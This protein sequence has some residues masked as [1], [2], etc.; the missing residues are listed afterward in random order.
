MNEI[1][2]SVVMIT[3]GHEKYIEEA[4]RGV[5]IQQTDF[6]I[7]LIIANDCSPDN[8]DEV[9]KGLIEDAPPNIEVKYSRHGENKGMM[10]NFIWALGQA[11]GKYIALCEGD[12]YWVDPYKLQKQ[13]D[14]METNPNF[15]M[16]FSG[17]EDIIENNLNNYRKITSF[18]KDRIFTGQEILDTWVV[19]TAS[20]LF[21]SRYVKE[22]D[23]EKTDSK[24]FIYGDIVLFLYLSTKGQIYGFKDKMV[25][26]RRHAD[27]VSVNSDVFG[28]F[29]KKYYAHLCEIIAVFGDKFKTPVF[30][31]QLSEISLDIAIK[32]LK[33]WH[34]LSAMRFLFK[35]I[36]HDYKKVVRGVILK[37]KFCK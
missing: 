25:A 14:F 28:N 20:V 10:P 12:D 6:N 18:D 23:Y 27:G 2:V 17:A 11:K 4:I 35:S 32:E 1:V 36:R 29:Q 16:I 22:E 13:V 8:T 33:K 26:Y 31:R 5:Y 15:S 19:P 21:R 24:K 7:E 37:I 9:V 34:L 30:R 3:Y